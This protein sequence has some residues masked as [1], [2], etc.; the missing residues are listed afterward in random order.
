MANGGIGLQCE[1]N[2]FYAGSLPG[3]GIAHGH[4]KAMQNPAKCS[5]VQQSLGFELTAK[6]K[7]WG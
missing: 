1:V 3:S 5:T 6:F 7:R 2:W 4:A